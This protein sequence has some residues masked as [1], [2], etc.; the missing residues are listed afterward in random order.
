MFGLPDVGIW[1]VYLLCIL[2]A[3]ICIVYGIINWNKGSE[4]E[5]ESIKEELAWQEKEAEIEE[6]L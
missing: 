5:A 2:S 6:K 1:L 4:N 3:M